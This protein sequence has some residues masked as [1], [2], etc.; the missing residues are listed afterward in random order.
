MLGECT[1]R[2]E[3]WQVGV[4]KRH[5]GIRWLSASRLKM[6]AMPE[7]DLLPGRRVPLWA[8]AVSVLVHA[9]V[10]IWPQQ[11]SMREAAPARIE[12]R[13]APRVS[14]AQPEAVQDT[15]AKSSS[16]RRSPSAPVAVLTQK[17]APSR[18]SVA[19]RREMNDFLDSL[20]RE[21]RSAPRPSLAQR[22]LAMAREAGQQQERHE[23]AGTALLELRPNAQP[24]D[25]FSLDLYVDGLV[26]RLNRS[27]AYVNNDPRSRGVRTASVQFRVNPDGSLKAFEVLNAGDQAEEIAFIRSVVERAIPFAQFPPDL[28]RAARSLAITICIKPGAGGGD[29]FGFTRTGG[30]GC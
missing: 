11:E 28:D 4:T 26:R 27:A 22:S 16:K 9:L 23:S 2:Q 20:D 18:W 29:G 21:A 19:E 24:P 25:P 5:K 10:L 30:R 7:H 14:R 1:C 3:S 17:S 12:A 15:P 8:I 13:L 6:P